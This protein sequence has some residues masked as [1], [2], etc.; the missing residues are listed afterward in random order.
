MLVDLFLRQDYYGCGSFLNGF[1]VLDVENDES[2]VD[3]NY[4]NNV[5]V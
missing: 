1:I 3:V 5:E 4:E 2:N